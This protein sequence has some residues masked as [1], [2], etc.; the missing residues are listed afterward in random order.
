M[1]PLFRKEVYEAQRCISSGETLIVQPLASKVL[2]L[3]ALCVTI[4]FLLFLSMGSYTSKTKVKGF[5]EPSDGLLPVWAAQGGLIQEVYVRDRQPVKKN[6]PLFL[7]VKQSA[8]LSHS[9]TST[10]VLRSLKLQKS[11]LEKAIETEHALGASDIRQLRSVQQ[12]NNQLLKQIILEKQLIQ[13]K[14]ESQQSIVDSYKRLEHQGYSSSIEFKKAKHLLL[15][16]R[17]QGQNLSKSIFNLKND[18]ARS[19][20]EQARRKMLADKEIQS[21]QQQVFNLEKAIAEQEQA[22]A[23]VIRAPDNGL[24]STLRVHKNQT[25]NS[26]Q[27]LA[28]LIPEN[29]KL[30]A[31][32][33]IPSKASGLIKD[34]QKVA[35]RYDAFPYQKFGTEYGYI[36]DIDMTLTMPGERP[37]PTP[38]N[39]PAYLV[40]VALDTQAVEAFGKSYSL[41]AGM[42][43]E[44]DIELETRSI[45]EW[46]FEPIIGFSKKV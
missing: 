13:E 27:M 20:S 10:A 46:L 3:L 31:I 33:V 5:L 36:S 7:I 1:N 6:D 23:A 22:F 21:L 29:S 17:S 45:L 9:D 24:V 14:I 39:E 30:K 37:I 32:L 44:A 40:S 16:Y 34:Q 28:T 26:N 38:I 41:K 19:E 25:I 12:E 15:D 18:I 2:C 4:I 8:S 42:I 43:L 35:L 11:S